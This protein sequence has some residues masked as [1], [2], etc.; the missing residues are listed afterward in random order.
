MKTLIVAFILGISFSAHNVSGMYFTE[1]RYDTKV[2]MT[3]EG[4]LSARCATPDPEGPCDQTSSCD[5]D[6][7]I[8]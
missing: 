5:K 4:T 7:V 3:K 6:D 1:E 8:R 2:C